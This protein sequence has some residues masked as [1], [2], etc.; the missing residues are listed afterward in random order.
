MLAKSAFF[1][2][3]SVTVADYASQDLD[4][5]GILVGVRVGTNFVERAPRNFPNWFMVAVICPKANHF[6]FSV[7][8]LAPNGKEMMKVDL[9]CHVEGPEFGHARLNSIIQFPPIPF[10]GLGDYIIRIKDE[11]GATVYRYPLSFKQGNP[12]RMTVTAEGKATLNPE[13]TKRD[14]VSTAS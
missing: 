7:S 3:E 14:Q 10:P 8:V 12:E 9:D 11:S 4:G 1:D 5:K 2:V 13:F 6:A